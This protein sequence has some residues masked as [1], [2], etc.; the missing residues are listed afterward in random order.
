MMG[1]DG[2][3]VMGIRGCHHLKINQNLDRGKIKDILNLNKKI[4]I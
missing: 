1:D 3:R 2:R 4:E